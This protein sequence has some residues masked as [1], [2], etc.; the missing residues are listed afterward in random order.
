VIIGIINDRI[1]GMAV[2]AETGKVLDSWFVEAPHYINGI[3]QGAPP[4]ALA[5]RDILVKEWLPVYDAG[6]QMAP[7]VKLRW[8]TEGD[9]TGWRI[10]KSV[11]YKRDTTGG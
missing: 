6:V 5:I 9:K 8:A 1:P 4:L 7:V 10:E 3:P 2:E 11:V